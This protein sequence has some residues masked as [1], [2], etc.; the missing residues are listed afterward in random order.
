MITAKEIS[1]GLPKLSL[2]ELFELNKSVIKTIRFKQSHECMELAKKFSIGDRV[3]WN[4]RKL[5]GKPMTGI[6]TKCNKSTASVEVASSTGKPIFWNVA[7][8]FL[9]KVQ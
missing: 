4:S 6:I 7:W 8:S 1:A 2:E 5:L 3:Q 9:E